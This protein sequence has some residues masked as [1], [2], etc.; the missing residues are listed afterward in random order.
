MES[1][2]RADQSSKL[3]LKCRN[4]CFKTL[5][6][7]EVFNSWAA[8]SPWNHPGFPWK[9]E[10][11]CVPADSGAGFEDPTINKEW[12][13]ALNNAKKQNIDFSLIKGAA[14]ALCARNE[15]EEL[16][17]TMECGPEIKDP[18]RN[19]SSWSWIFVCIFISFHSLISAADL[20]SLSVFSPLNKMQSCSLNQH[21]PNAAFCGDHSIWEALE[22]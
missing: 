17:I 6:L 22:A 16:R 18:I 12:D 1:T 21:L 2:S 14:S 11:E 3:C 13:E 15:A 7:V 8:P 20:I 10:W 9:M 19:S 4:R 5:H